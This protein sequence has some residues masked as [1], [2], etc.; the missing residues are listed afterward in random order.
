MT[1]AARRANRLSSTG[2]YG[3]CAPAYLFLST[4]KAEMLCAMELAEIYVFKQK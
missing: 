4:Q 3:S 2:T 1:S